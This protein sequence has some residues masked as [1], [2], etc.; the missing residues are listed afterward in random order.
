MNRVRAYSFRQIPNCGNC[1]KPLPERTAVKGLRDVYLWRKPLGFLS[2]A[3]MVVT[4]VAW[5][6]SLPTDSK[7]IAIS[8][9]SNS[10]T[11]EPQPQEGIYKWYGPLWGQDL[12]ELTIKTAPGSNYFVKLVDASGRTARSYFIQ[13]GFTETFPVPLGTFA[14]K[15]A[16]GKSWCSEADLFG[17]DTAVSQADDTFT[18]TED[19][20]WTVELIL[21]RHGN[22]RTHLIS[23]SEF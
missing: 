16:I 23:R 10:C 8:L 14:L 3:A 18:F 9:P 1:H 5:V 19:Q 6:A 4:A 12:S 20:S 17:P 21:Q 7:S 13:G 15:Y 2:V 11:A 22:L